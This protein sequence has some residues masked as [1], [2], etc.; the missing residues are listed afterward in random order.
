MVES[1]AGLWRHAPLLALTVVAI[2][3]LWGL[4]RVVR[5]RKPVAPARKLPFSGAPE[6]PANLDSSHIGGPLFEST[7]DPYGRMTGPITRGGGH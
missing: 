4:V 6:D 5:S 3:V 1:I 2:A 7:V